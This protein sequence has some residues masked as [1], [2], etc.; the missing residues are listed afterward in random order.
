MTPCPACGGA[1]F[2]MVDDWIDDGNRHVHFRHPDYCP[3]KCITPQESEARFKA[4]E[5]GQAA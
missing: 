5:K 1:G 3:A 4:W 2:V